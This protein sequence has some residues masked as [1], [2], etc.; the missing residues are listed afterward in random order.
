MLERA[1]TPEFRHLAEQLF[2][3]S[4]EFRKLERELP[5]QIVENRARREGKPVKLSAGQKRFISEAERDAVKANAEVGAHYHS[6]TDESQLVQSALQTECFDRKT[7]AWL[8]D[9]LHADDQPMATRIRSL[10]DSLISEMEAFLQSHRSSKSV[11]AI[12]H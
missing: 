7:W 5:G 6:L 9:S 3:T 4:E 1:R 12:E 11:S 2:A 8:Y 10:Q